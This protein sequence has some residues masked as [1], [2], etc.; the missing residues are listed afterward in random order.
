MPAIPSAPAQD[1]PIAATPSTALA[2]VL[3]I[4]LLLAL[5]GLVLVLARMRAIRDEHA[6]ELE[7]IS[8]LQRTFGRTPP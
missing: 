7:A 4:V 1:M 2:L 3:S 5:G 6:V 8:E